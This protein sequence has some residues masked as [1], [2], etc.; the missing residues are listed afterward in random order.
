MLVTNNDKKYNNISAEE[1]TNFNLY[2]FERARSMQN[3]IVYEY[4]PGSDTY[5]A[6]AYDGYCYYEI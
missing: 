1:I 6:Y 2:E 4:N 3:E 5:T